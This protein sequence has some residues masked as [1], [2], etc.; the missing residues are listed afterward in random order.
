MN[1]AKERGLVVYQDRFGTDTRLSAPIVRKFLVQGRS[2]YV[3]DQEIYWFIA[4]CKALKLNPFTRDCW[5]IKYSQKENAQIIVSKDFYNARLD[6]QKDLEWWKAGI[7]VRRDCKPCNGSGMVQEAG[8]DTVCKLCEGEGLIYK[9]RQ[10]AMPREGDFLVGGW[11]EAKKRARSQPNYLEVSLPAYIKTTREGSITQFW[12]PEMQPHMIRKVAFNQGCREMYPDE[13]G[14]VYDESEAPLEEPL[15]EGDV[16]LTLEDT[17]PARDTIGELQEKAAARAAEI[18]PAAEETEEQLHA[19]LVKTFDARTENLDPDMVR[20]K[21]FQAMEKLGVESIPQAK[22]II[23]RDR[24]LEKFIEEIQAQMEEPSIL[25]KLPPEDEVTYPPVEDAEPTEV[26]E[27]QPPA[28][29]PEP[30]EIVEPEPAEPPEPEPTKEEK[31]EKAPPDPEELLARIKTGKVAT[32]V[33]IINEHYEHFVSK[34]MDTDVV[35]QLGA[36]LKRLTNKSLD[37]YLE[38]ITS[39]EKRIFK[40]QLVQYQTQ[41]VEKIG[42]EEAEKL[43]KET[44]AK[45]DTHTIEGI[46][47]SAYEPFLSDYKLAI[48]HAA[49]MSVT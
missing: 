35:I 7:I 42:R 33:D 30:E 8:V 25:P 2:E 49:S 40:S 31:T 23:M 27:T 20:D 28:E 22:V 15:P 4:K 24:L 13:Y 43:Y 14:G 29:I 1:E 48:E 38:E 21:L 5:F 3:N 16:I 19:A 11:F 6:S 41:A 44:L 39:E 32:L 17:E 36:K 12:R 9:N 47:P 34:E 10:G 26:V 46:Y 18:P 45:Y 37:A